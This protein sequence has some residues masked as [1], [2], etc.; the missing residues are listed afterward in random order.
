MARVQPLCATLCVSVQQALSI[1]LT[2][3]RDEFT[4]LVE[5]VE[6]NVSQLKI[7]EELIVS[8]V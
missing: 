5:T 6:G 4:R 8:N 1:R 7:M 2:D 3:Q